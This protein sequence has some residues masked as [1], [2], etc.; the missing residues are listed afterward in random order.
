MYLFVEKGTR[1]GIFYISKRY[2]KVNNKYMQ[3]YDDKKL[4]KYITY[5]DANNLYG[6]GMSQYLPYGGFKWLNKEEIDK[7]DVNSIKENS[8]NKYILEVDLEYPDELHNDYP[9]APEKLEIS[10]DM[11]SDYCSNIANKYKIKIGGVN[12]LIPNLGNKK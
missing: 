9:L 10:H 2:S 7:F 1:G 12:K 3:F 8:S 11:L 6:W 4:S 5:L